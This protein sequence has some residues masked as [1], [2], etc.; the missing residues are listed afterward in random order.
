MAISLKRFRCFIALA[1]EL[2]FGRAAEHIFLSQPALSKQIAHLEAD[3]GVKLFERTPHG[4]TLTRAG[5]VLLPEARLVLG[6]V[7]RAVRSVAQFSDLESSRLRLGAVGP[8]AH[9]LL[10]KIIKM[11]RV[12]RPELV[13]SLNEVPTADQLDLLRNDVIDLA[14][15]CAEDRNDIAFLPLF[16]DPVLVGLPKASPLAQRAAVSIKSLGEQTLASPHR[17]EPGHARLLSHLHGQG[18]HPAV[19]EV[20]SVTT[21][22]A[23]ISSG[24]AVGFFPAFARTNPPSGVTLLPIEP[25]MPGL[26]TG[27]AWRRATPPAMLEA[28]LAVAKEVARSLRQVLDA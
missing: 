16:C 15:L 22:F 17:V 5:R 20:D 23:L 10:P 24:E 8:A 26:E 18:I 25:A 27:V 9:V 21:T 12:T 2:H 28:F 14:L 19:I 6:Q 1:E 13:I 3:L 11:I 7:E 4:V